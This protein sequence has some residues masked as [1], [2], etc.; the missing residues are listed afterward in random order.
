MKRSIKV[1]LLLMLPFL[2]ACAVSIDD[3]AQTQPKLDLSQFFNGHLEAYGIVQDYKGKVTRRFTADILGQWRDGKGVL[4]EQFIF[5]DGE[6]QHRCWRLEKD[7]DQYRGTAGDVVGTAQGRV[8]G[9]ALNWQYILS[10]PINNKEIDISL[11]DWMYL[12]NEDSL[13]NRAS[14]KKFGVEVG[15]ITLY[16]RKVSEHAH[17]PL[18][19]K[20]SIAS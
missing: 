14:M 7:G 1:A 15:Q 5:A 9:N 4:D 20:C 16:I 12:V 11:N 17:R 18:T 10:V 8:A 6:L 2:S 13:I 3:Y 19:D